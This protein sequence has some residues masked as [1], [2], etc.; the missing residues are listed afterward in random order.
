MPLDLAQVVSQIKGLAARLKA[1]E[2]ERGERL[3]R[4]LTLL[5]TADIEPLRSKTA[6]SKTTWLVAGLIDGLDLR[7]EAPPRPSEFSVIATD[8]S[9]IDVDRHNSV[10][11]CLINIGSVLLHYGENP[12][13]DLS[14][15]A[16]VLSGDGLFIV[17]PVGGREEAIEG[18]LLGVKRG[19][20]E[21]SALARLAHEQAGERPTLALVDGSL[22]LWGLAGQAFHEFV[23]EALLEK[24]FLRVLDSLRGLSA[25]ERFA[26]ASYISFPRSADV[27][28]ALRVALCPHEIPD[29]D[30]F[31]P[32]GRQRECDAIAGVQDRDVF[33]AL[34]GPG[35]R[36]A[37]F[38]SRSSIV[39]KH[40]GDHEIHFFYLKV[41]GEVA[42]VE[43]PRWV[44]ESDELV[45][46]V[47]ALVLDQC[48]RGHGYPVAL[49]EAHEKAVVTTADRERF[50]EL[51]ELS[52]FEDGMEL[53]SS[54]KSRSKQ[55]RWV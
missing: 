46:L 35:E 45:G 31:C 30:R 6:A 24:E 18:P 23:K 55:T 7:H 12:D 27:V 52:L 39:R 15:E 13:A 2:R 9:H 36:S 25:S 22:I 14:S 49:M 19:V 3:E 54:G 26:V 11:C 42:R 38:A 20:E 32:R 47:H 4:A 34:L 5:S 33:D 1:G 48:R 37:T 53:E 29:C 16:T 17:D 51:V 28:N 10:P 41:D 44:A 8:G 40:Y 43:V 21:L 50:W